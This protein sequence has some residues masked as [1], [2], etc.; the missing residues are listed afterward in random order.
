MGR[1]VKGGLIHS[2]TRTLILQHTQRAADAAGNA[3]LVQERFDSSL[4][5]ILMTREKTGVALTVGVVPVVLVMA[6]AAAV[7]IDVVPFS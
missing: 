1:D 6:S 4:R 3:Q 2:E 5:Y 7:E